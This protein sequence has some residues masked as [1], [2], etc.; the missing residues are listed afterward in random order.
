MRRWI[1]YCVFTLCII[2]LGILL[3][4]RNRREEA[5][6][7]VVPDGL[8]TEALKIIKDASISDKQLL[9]AIEA[10]RQHKVDEPPEFWIEIA[11]G[12]KFAAIHR[13]RCFFEFFRRHVPFGS[14]MSRLLSIK[15][16]SGWFNDEN[17]FGSTIAS[18]VP[19]E[20][21]L[22]QTIWGIAPHFLKETQSALYI[23][24]ED[25]PHLVAKKFK[26]IMSGTKKDIIEYID[27]TIE[28]IGYGDEYL[29]KY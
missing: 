11:N 6:E 26:L 4:G 23:S 5:I 16:V 2:V 27:L 20:R 17:I 22:G 28:Q 19:I 21:H 29:G 12:E 24:F 25:E 13:T 8:F 18:Y 1:G 3:F 10:I 9:Q 14:K 7:P 15:G